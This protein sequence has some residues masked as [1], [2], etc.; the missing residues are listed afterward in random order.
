MKIQTNYKVPNG[1]ERN[2]VLD[3]PGLRFILLVCFGFRASNFGFVILR[4][5]CDATKKGGK[6]MNSNKSRVVR[7]LVVGT[8][9]SLGMIAPV[10]AQ[11]VV[12]IGFVPS[13]S[14]APLFIG[15]ERGYFKALGV[16][17]ELVRLPSGAA[18]LTQV[19][20]G[21]IQV[22]GGALGAAAFNAA[23]QKLPV[24][25]VAPM[26]F[27]YNEDYLVVR[28]AE[29]DAG[30]FKSVADLRGK[31]CAVNAKG[32]ATEWVLDEVLKTGGLR[33]D[34]I[35]LRTLPFPEM[36]PALENGAIV[37]GI[38]TEPFATQAEEK[39][40][41]VRP[42]K[43]KPGA[44]PVPITVAFW[45]SDWAKKNDSVAKVFMNGYLRA[46]RDLS[47]PNAWKIPMH[48]EIISK[49]TGV[50]AAV[51]LKTRPPVFSTN[52]ELE[53]KEMMSQQEFNL[54]LGYLKYKEMKPIKELLDLSYAEAA[55][56]QAGRK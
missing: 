56:K 5:S 20:T 11:S 25:F 48:T 47:E 42:L 27:A 49:H 8:V 16:T 35:D 14:F 19:S 32:V 54:R 17:T 2:E 15:H 39:G 55:V 30:R 10:Q 40:I 4:H 29:I 51:L 12:K 28:K 23:H 26:H 34:N 53:D 41:G 33:I 3:F 7:M 46:V 24:A 36:L 1:M 31:P 6:S 21:D 44:K 52:L 13:E 22:G 50:A 43:A 45:N 18:I 37:C 38:V 9:M